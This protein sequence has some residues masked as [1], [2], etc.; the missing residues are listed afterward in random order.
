MREDT[1]PEAE[2]G[3]GGSEVEG[4]GCPWDL[5]Q[6]MGWVQ[7]LEL[8]ARSSTFGSRSWSSSSLV[9]QSTCEALQRALRKSAKGSGST[10]A[11]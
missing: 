2:H 10:S 3:P 6:L 4:S 8:S 11:C 9:S 7:L 1:H 5:G